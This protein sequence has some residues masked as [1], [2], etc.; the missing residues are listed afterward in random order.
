MI[1]AACNVEAKR[2]RHLGSDW[3]GCTKVGE[4]LAS[5]DD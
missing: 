1:E 3:Y 5:K 2:H 4:R